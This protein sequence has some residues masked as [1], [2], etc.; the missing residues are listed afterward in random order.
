MRMMNISEIKELQRD[1]ALLYAGGH[2]EIE[3]SHPEYPGV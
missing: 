3:G 1:T 2:V